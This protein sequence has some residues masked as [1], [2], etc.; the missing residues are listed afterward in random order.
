MINW[1]VIALDFSIICLSACAVMCA[2]QIRNLKRRVLHLELDILARDAAAN[3][4]KDI[5]ERITAN[6]AAQT[7]GS[8]HGINIH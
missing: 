4:I 5:N 2:Y 7:V 3:F 8:E 1:T 6:R